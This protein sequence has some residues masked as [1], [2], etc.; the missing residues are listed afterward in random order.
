M[1]QV[2]VI[3]GLALLAALPAAAQKAPVY[4]CYVL[5]APADGYVV[6]GIA[7]DDDF[8][9]KNRYP[10]SDL[11]GVKNQCRSEISKLQKADTKPIA[12]GRVDLSIPAPPPPEPPIPPT[13]DELDLAAFQSRV[14][15][16]LKLAVIVP[17]DDKDLAELRTQNAADL[18]AHPEWKDSI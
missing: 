4:D 18:K 12:L 8:I 5:E 17:A 13:Q 7:K 3:L 15:L 14:A 1:K 11:D 10:L 6:L 16:T 2:T 9:F